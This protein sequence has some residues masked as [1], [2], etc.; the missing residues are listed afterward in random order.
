MSRLRRPALRLLPLTLGVVLIAAPASASCRKVLPRSFFEGTATTPGATAPV[1]RHSEQASRIAALLAAGRPVI[2]AGVTVHGPL[3]LPKHL[4]VPLVL[5]RS[6]FLGPV[7]GT[8]ATFENLVDFTNS[9]FHAG[10]D[11]T[12]AHFREPLLF[13]RAFVRDGQ[14][15]SFAFALFD[16]AAIVSGTRFGGPTTFDGAEFNGTSRFTGAQF[17]GPATFRL[18]SLARLADFVNATFERGASFADAEL[19]S[20]GDFGGAQFANSARFDGV[21]FSGL[22]EFIGTIFAT[23]QQPAR[24]DRARFDG[25]ASFANALFIDGAS[26]YLLRGTQNLDF[27]SAQIEKTIDFSTAQLLG[28]TSFPHAGVHGLLN[29]D[30]AVVRSLDLRGAQLYKFRIPS[31][32]GSG[33]IRSLRIGP[34]DSACAVD[35]DGKY[36]RAAQERVLTLG[37]QAATADHDLSS[38]NDAEIRLRSMERDSRPFVPRMLDWAFWWGVLGY[39]VL[40]VHQLILIGLV[41]VIGVFVR[42][43][44]TRGSVED[45]FSASVDSLLRLTP[46]KSG[47]AKV[48]YLVFKFLVV[49]LIVNVSNVWPPFRDLFQGVF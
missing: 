20:V 48:E 32:D 41:F 39:F 6:C 43:L 4:S 5:R 19:R 26:F 30:Q 25:D 8:H 7:R 10:V 3:L 46:P 2:E 33:G 11:F 16:S 27:D 18:A 40:P 49:V 14:R 44:N 22:A 23:T 9:S 12:G 45:D 47:A 13:S 42:W 38:A 35:A 1:C 24:F 37:Q 17:G 34:A 29:L 28:D 36:A 31:T 21:H 15:A